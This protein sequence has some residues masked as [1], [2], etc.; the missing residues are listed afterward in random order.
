MAVFPLDGASLSLIGLPE[1]I[2]TYRK[3]K[4]LTGEPHLKVVP[5][6]DKVLTLSG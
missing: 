3:T 2:M 4:F 1:R 5:I 6:L